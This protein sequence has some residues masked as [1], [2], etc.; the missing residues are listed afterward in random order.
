VEI[1]AIPIALCRTFF[2]INPGEKRKWI[3]ENTGETWVAVRGETPL[4]KYFSTYKQFRLQRRRGVNKKLGRDW[5]NMCMK[6]KN[7]FKQ[8]S[9]FL[10]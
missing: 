1:L 7:F 2:Q 6:N 3:F 4:P 5:G 9:P 8:S 10:T